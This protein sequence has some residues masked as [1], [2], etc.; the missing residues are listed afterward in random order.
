MS[1]KCSFCHMLIT[2]DA[3]AFLGLWWH[4]TCLQRIK[5]KISSMSGDRGGA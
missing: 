5:R 1:R 3:K 4:P 2:H